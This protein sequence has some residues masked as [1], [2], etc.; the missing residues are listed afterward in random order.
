ME[1]NAREVYETLGACATDWCEGCPMFEEI[2]GCAISEEKGYID[3]P[4]EIVENAVGILRGFIPRVL[5]IDE[6]HPRMALWLEDRDKEDVILA[7]GGS[8]CTGAK[9]FITENDMSIAPK[10][11]E[12]GI[13]W[14][15]WNQKPSNEQRYTEEWQNASE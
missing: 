9:C 6:I 7:I 10:D 8:S 3:L 12:Y 5:T 15:A 2:T 11:C 4:K 13:R 1:L 14:R